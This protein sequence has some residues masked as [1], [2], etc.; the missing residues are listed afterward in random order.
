VGRVSCATIGY[1]SYNVKKE[2]PPSCHSDESWN[3]VID[4]REEAKARRIF[5]LVIARSL[6]RAGGECNPVLKPQ[7][8]TKVFR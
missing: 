3:R 5:S 2:M 6:S 1:I 8:N 4:S 7:I